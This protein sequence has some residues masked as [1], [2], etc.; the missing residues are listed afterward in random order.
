VL[1][2]ARRF[3]A[4]SL[5]KNSAFLVINLA[6]GALCGYGSLTILTRIFSVRDVGLSATAVA[7]CSL[8]TFIT[9]FGVTYS[10]PRYLPT[11]KNRSA[12]INT[13]LT[14]VVLAT[15]LGS[16]IFLAL[17]YA[18]NLFALG[19]ILFCVAF[20]VTCC[21]QAGQTVLSTVLI[22]DRSADKVATYGM[23][24]NLARLAAPAAL[25]SLGALG[26]FIARVIADL[27]GF[28]TFGALIA[29]KGHK[30]RPVIDVPVTKEIAKFSAG[31]YVANIVG[32]M[33]QL[34]LPLIVLS[35]VGASQAA[36]WSIAISIGSLL[37]SLP[38]TVTQAL[39]PEV[40]LRPAER[41]VLLRR[42]TYLITVIVLPALVIGFAGAPYLLALFGRSY[43]TGT[44]VPLRWLIFAGLITMLNYVTGAILF[45]AKKSTMITIVNVVDAIIVLGLVTLWATNVSQ[46]AIAWVIGDV[47]NTVLFGLFAFIALRQ[48]GGRWEALGGP[49]SPDAAQAPASLTATSQM[50]A[51]GMLVTLAEQ[52]NTV[53][54]FKPYHNSLTDSQGLFSIVALQAAERQRQRFIDESEAAPGITPQTPEQSTAEQHQALEVLF[55]L[56]QQ[57]RGTR[58]HKPPPAHA[59]GRRVPA[60]ARREQPVKSGDQPAEPSDRPA[61]SREE[62]AESRDQ[63]E[64]PVS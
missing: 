5:F 47:G 53:D 14:T 4:E 9:Q 56:A 36:Y 15:L 7:A 31:M 52:Q 22:A 37:F 32:G 30:F 45:I 58:E 61:E 28:V 29:R 35:R 44:L 62:P 8:V 64:T 50:R 34:L 12:M 16:V 60:H 57:Q 38:S 27:F 13:M 6:V 23:I 63:G 21:L 3:F 49:I 39:L 24:P 17:P 41:R 10:L 1:N 19:G 2:L 20:V 54:M 55:A 11:A 33:P 42:S 59:A 26:A 43:V 46:V 40:S 18:K 48:V 25:S 51:V